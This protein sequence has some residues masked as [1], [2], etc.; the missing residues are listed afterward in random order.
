MTAVQA[1]A[2]RDAARATQ[3]T[4]TAFMTETAFEEAQRILT[5][6]SRFTLKDA[7]WRA[8]NEILER[9]TTVKPRLA[10]LLAS[11]DVIG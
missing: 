8:F 5:D 1:V 3:R 9:P 4:V 10:A 7:E 6:S 11:D 2:I